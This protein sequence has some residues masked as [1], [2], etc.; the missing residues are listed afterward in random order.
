MAFALCFAFV[1][2]G[3]K[4]EF[5]DR[6]QA[7]Y[8]LVLDA[9]YKFK[10]PSAVR[11]VSGKAEYIP[12]TDEN[13]NEK[14]YS[15]LEL[16]RG[17][18]ISANLRLSST[19][20]YGATTTDYWHIIYNREGKIGVDDINKTM[21]DFMNLMEENPRLNRLSYL[22]CKLPL[23]GTTNVKYWMTLILIK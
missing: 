21:K 22:R 4:N 11:I 9:S 13:R 7:I 16:E 3:D 20:G 8:Q 14:E 2:C 19:N 5:T 6:E 1:G 23:I 10:N 18:F 15:E 17:Y 12:I